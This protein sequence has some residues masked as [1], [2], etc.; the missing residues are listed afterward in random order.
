MA[1]VRIRGLEPLSV[2]LGLITM[3]PLACTSYDTALSEFDAVA[4][5]PA[6][7]V[8]PE[9]LNFISNPQELP[10]VVDRNFPLGRLSRRK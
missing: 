4:R 1:R 3:L 5:V 6:M 9:Q 8:E 10:W 7:R 2:L